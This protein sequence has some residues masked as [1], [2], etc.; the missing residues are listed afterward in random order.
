MRNIE[1]RYAAAITVI[2]LSGCA[3]PGTNWMD[4]TLPAAPDVAEIAPKTCVV[5]TRIN[6]RQYG[7][8][9]PMP[10]RL[11]FN[12][13]PSSGFASG[14]FT[15]ESGT[16]FHAVTLR[17]G[18]HQWREIYMGSAG[19]I[20]R[21]DFIFNCAEKTVTYIGDVEIKLEIATRKYTIQFPD[22]ASVT[23][24]E[25]KARY[26]VLSAAHKLVLSPV[27]DPRGLW[28]KIDQPAAKP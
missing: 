20:F 8:P 12:D 15:L 14:L 22:M 3:S 24:F 27:K 18:S 23:E 10:V 13:I 19:S 1:T 28:R 6:Y 7:D 4:L 16:S 5:V 11:T 21:D 2:A 25:Y 26:P 17:A 9:L